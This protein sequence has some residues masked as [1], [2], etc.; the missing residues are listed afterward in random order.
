[1]RE[2]TL[3][4]GFEARQGRALGLSI[5]RLSADP[6]DDVGRLENLVEI[7]VDQRLSRGS[8]NAEERGVTGE[9]P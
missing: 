6:V 4:G 2:E 3:L 1:L 8:G 7:L 5:Q 9:F